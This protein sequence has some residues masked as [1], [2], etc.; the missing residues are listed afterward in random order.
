MKVM[1]P[2]CGHRSRI[3]RDVQEMPW[4]GDCCVPM[5][6]PLLTAIRIVEEGSSDLALSSV[7]ATTQTQTTGEKQ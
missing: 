5:E 6:T 4:C 2:R 7:I 1:C 3:R